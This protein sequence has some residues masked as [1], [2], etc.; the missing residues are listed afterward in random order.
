MASEET[1]EKDIT[2][3]TIIQQTFE[4]LEDK[5]KPLYTIWTSDRWNFY[6]IKSAELYKEGLVW[7]HVVSAPGIHDLGELWTGSHHI[8][9]V[10]DTSL[11]WLRSH[12]QLVDATKLW[13]RPYLRFLC[14]SKAAFGSREG[15][16]LVDRLR[17]MASLPWLR[18]SIRF[19]YLR[20]L[21]GSKAAIWSRDSPGLEDCLRKVAL[22]CSPRDFRRVCL[23]HL[24]WIIL[25]KDIQTLP[26]LAR[27]KF[28]SMLLFL[29]LSSL[30]D[31]S[32][33]M[34]TQLLAI[35]E[36]GVLKCFGTELEDLAVLLPDPRTAMHQIQ[37]V[38]TILRRAGVT[39]AYLPNL[40]DECFDVFSHPASSP[41]SSAIS[42]LWGLRI[43]IP[44]QWSKPAIGD[45]M[46]LR[47]TTL[48]TA[49]MESPQEYAKIL[50]NLEEDEY[51]PIFLEDV[52]F[53]EGHPKLS[54]RLLRAAKSMRVGQII[55][56]HF[57][58]EMEAKLGIIQLVEIT[59]L[60]KVMRFE[61][62]L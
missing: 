54:P 25:S 12:F 42:E 43:A 34:A 47:V 14:G 57:T 10:E 16:G 9:V 30:E 39:N 51:S 44:N 50:S 58:L 49:S 41:C 29:A 24:D 59:S 52:L 62:S 32:G 28:V 11:P 38:R 22:G 21:Y 17:K 4:P 1:S 2:M 7:D 45:A 20:F 31:H 48:P 26:P 37:L 46:K 5:I 27:K 3:T 55:A 61:A 23:S 15:Q 35:T 36:T 60:G 18:S 6:S 8:V 13:H 19:P 56:V 33:P 53:T 40:S